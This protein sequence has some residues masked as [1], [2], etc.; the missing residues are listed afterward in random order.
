MTDLANLDHSLA[1]ATDLGI[2]RLA[3]LLGEGLAG[4][5]DGE[6]FLEYR[7]TESLA[8]DDGRLKSAAFDTSSGFG[9]R[10]V[11]GEAIG[12]AHSRELSEAAIRRAI[13]AMQPVKRGHSGSLDL[14][15]QGTNR[16]RYGEANPI[17][18]RDQAIKIGLLEQIDA[19]ARAKEP[20]VRQVS[21]AL[22]GSWQRVEIVRPDGA[23]R[24]DVRPLVRLNVAVVVGDGRRMESGSFGAGGRF[25]YADLLEPAKW[26]SMVDEAVREALIKLEAVAAPAG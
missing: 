10:G 6:L 22:S 5:D 7:E 21:A 11:A 9:L 4:V 3:A 17:E 8:F 20:R 16:K 12:Y 15:P 26:R 14:P 25:G 19:Y 23:R 18:G 1:S 2:D 13:D 24:S